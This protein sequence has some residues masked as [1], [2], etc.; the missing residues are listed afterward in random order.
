MTESSAVPTIDPVAERLANVLDRARAYVL[1]R[2]SPNGGF[3]FYRTSDINEPSLSDTWHA[4]AALRLLNVAPPHSDSIIKFVTEQ[5]PQA[6]AYALYFR[7]RILDALQTLDPER[8]TVA[9]LVRSLPAR[10]RPSDAAFEHSDELERLH[11]TLW[12]NKHFA[13]P[14]ATRALGS[15]LSALEHPGGGFGTPANL[16]DTAEVLSIPSLCRSVSSPATRKLVTRLGVPGFGFRLTMSSLT[17]TLETTCAG[18]E[19]CVRLRLP[20]PYPKDTRDFILDC[21][22]GNGGFARAP[23]A[24][25]GLALTHLALSGLDHV[26]SD[27]A[28]A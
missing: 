4:I 3:S 19:C 17:P 22:T 13:L 15:V 11:L 12:L 2:Q 9:G 27:L 21:Q 20:V 23:G 24:L 10:L 14:F 28:I 18:I 26:R 8:A 7:V 16:L 1:G 25:A 6:Q 5:R